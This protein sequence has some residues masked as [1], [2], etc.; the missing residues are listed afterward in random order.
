M[1]STPLL[2]F[3]IPVYNEAETL[4]ELFHQIRSVVEANNLG[5]YEVIF[6][7]D[8]SGDNSWERITQLHFKNPRVVRGLRFRTNFGKAAALAEG[9]QEAQGETVFTLDADLQDDPKEIP[10]FLAKLDSGYDLVS[11][12][13]QNRRDPW[14]KTIPSWIFNG[15]TCR[16]AGI[17]L[18][19][20]N[21]GFKAYRREVVKNIRLYGEL[22]RYI[23]VLA[24]GEGFRISEIP[25][26]HHPRTTGKSKYGWKRYFRGFL[27]LLTVMTTTRYLQRPAHLFGGLGLL[28]GIVGLGILT[29]LSLSWLAGF[30][31][32]AGRPLFFFGILFT[33][34]SGQLLSLGL[35]A[36]L[37]LKTSNEENKR[38]YAKERLDLENG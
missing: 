28:L 35:I 10:A 26:V 5:G 7:D 29:Y 22:H 3:V 4:E 11:G 19:D 34:L 2:S 6:V 30:R 25:V 21:C 38:H 18:H 1:S 24:H 8:G 14:H 31:G 9:F 13:K 17:K 37:L 20:F 15:V 27:D 23:P 12:W 16:V 32:L 36:E 33:L